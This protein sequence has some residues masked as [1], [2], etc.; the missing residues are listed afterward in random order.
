M[1][2]IGEKDVLLGE[3]EKQV[4]RLLESRKQEKKNF[5]MLEQ[6]EQVC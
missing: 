4:D 3:L 6:R 1:T 2:E 5:R